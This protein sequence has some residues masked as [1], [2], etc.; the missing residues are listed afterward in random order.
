MWNREED[1]RA[2]LSM[3]I[4]N[5]KQFALNK[6]IPGG[7]KEAILEI[8]FGTKSLFAINTKAQYQV[9]TSHYHLVNLEEYDLYQGLLG[10]EIVIG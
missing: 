7:T 5:E 10:E 4:P 9:F 8:Y 3:H 6:H 2:A 1:S